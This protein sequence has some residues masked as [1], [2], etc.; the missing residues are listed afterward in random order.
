MEFLFLK[1]GTSCMLKLAYLPDWTVLPSPNNILG[2]GITL[3]SIFSLF[4]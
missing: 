4:E 2:N 3:A 1:I